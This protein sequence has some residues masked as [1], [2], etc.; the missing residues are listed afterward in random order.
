MARLENLEVC[1]AAQHTSHSY[2]LQL[3]SCNLYIPLVLCMVPV[4]CARG[5]TLFS[6]K[7]FVVLVYRPWHL[8]CAW[9][10]RKESSRWNYEQDLLVRH[11]IWQVT[12]G[13]ESV[14]SGI[15]QKRR[16]PSLRPFLVR[17]LAT[18]GPR[19]S[20]QDLGKRHLLLRHTCDGTNTVRSGWLAGWLALNNEANMA[21]AR[22]GGQYP[23]DPKFAP[24][25]CPA[26]RRS[27][28]A[29]PPPAPM[30]LRAA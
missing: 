26:E 20:L 27:V 7:H 11:N 8:V 2:R 1:I 28:H 15:K 17:E 22:G 6:P 9:C 16:V 14:P 25:T 18:R 10:E 30:T 24:P 29:T 13:L 5:S 19:P 4:L 3:W 21:D 23:G 12:N